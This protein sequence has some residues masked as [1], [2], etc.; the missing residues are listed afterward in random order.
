M[1]L[2]QRIIAVTLR[3]ASPHRPLTRRLI[4]AIP[5]SMRWRF[6]LSL[7]VLFA[8]VRGAD[9]EPRHCLTPTESRVAVKTHKVVPLAKAIRRVRARHPGDLVA[10]RMCE[11]GKRL[12]YVLTV[13]PRSGK[14][15]HASVDAATGAMVGGS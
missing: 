6:V 5:T 2:C 13:L 7:L 3:H 4:T 14:V 12:L 15:V 10:V 9:A 8:A 11:E 1:R